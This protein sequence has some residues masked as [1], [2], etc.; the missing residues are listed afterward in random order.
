[1]TD[2]RQ[3]FSDRVDDYVRYRP[4]YPAA[5][6]DTLLADAGDGATPV[7]ADI[8]SG[9]GIFT[10]LLLERG[11][12]VA[13]VEPNANMRQAAEVALQ[14]FP[15]FTSIDGSAEDTGLDLRSVD[16]VTAAQAFHWFNNGRARHEFARILKPG[17]QLAL[18]WN[19]RRLDEP[20]Q[21]AYDAL[22]REYSADYGRINHLTMADDEIGAFFAP[23]KMTLTQFENPQILDFDGL[24]G[25]L[26][27]A[28]YCPPENT[29]AYRALVADLQ[30]LFAKHA[31]D[32]ELRFAYDSRL[33]LGTLSN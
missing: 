11:A 13:G 14:S 26:R 23:G 3:R 19:R 15:A 22:L 32:G 27:S 5:L 9:T 7:V 16:L 21:Q 25:R 8:G 1:M 29:P 20:F 30:L 4:G 31:D 24:L 10:R 2:S 12:L 6:I 28:S 18:I 33:Y 17:G